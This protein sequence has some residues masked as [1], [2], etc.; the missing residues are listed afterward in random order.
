MHSQQHISPWLLSIQANF[1]HS[2]ASISILL[3]IKKLVEPALVFTYLVGCFQ[4]RVAL[5]A[6][7]GSFAEHGSVNYAQLKW[8]DSNA[9][10]FLM[11][12]SR[13]LQQVL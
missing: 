13:A 3:K 5:V 9:R 2:D 4:D 8:R 10:G 12:L 6:T 7:G 1:P 11:T